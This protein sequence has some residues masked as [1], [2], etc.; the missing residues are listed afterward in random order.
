MKRNMDLARAILLAIEES[1]SVVGFLRF[2]ISGA[3]DAEVSYHVMLLHEAGLIEAHDASGM[4]AHQW[5]PER[6]TWAGHEFLDASRDETMWNKAKK[7]IQ[8][9]GGSLT[10]EILK[11]VLVNLAK[12]AVGVAG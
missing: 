11:E 12:Q 8:D 7:L 1:D 4:N 3:T 10:F 9:K 5:F 2:T 6:L